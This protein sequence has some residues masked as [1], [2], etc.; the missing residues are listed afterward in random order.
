[1]NLIKRKAIL[2]QSYRFRMQPTKIKT[3]IIKAFIL[4]II[5]YPVIALVTSSGN[6]QNKLQKVNNKAPRFAMNKRHPYTRTSKI[7]HE[8]AGTEPIHYSLYK[9]AENI[10]TEV[11]NMEDPY[12]Q[13]IIE[14]YE[15]NSNH[16]Y[17]SKT[18]KNT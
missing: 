9:R 17:Y 16:R 13:Y 5:I 10:F 2:I 14:N 18:K 15:Q 11:Q 3:H 12:M 1:M 7:L 4:P 8:Q 6:Q